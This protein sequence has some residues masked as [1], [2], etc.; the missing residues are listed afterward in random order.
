VAVGRSVALRDLCGA[1]GADLAESGE[2]VSGNRLRVVAAAEGPVSDEPAIGPALCRGDMPD[3]LIGTL[4]AE[5]RLWAKLLCHEDE[6]TR[7][8]AVERVTEAVHLPGP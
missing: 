4:H 8:L 3:V 2:I 1:V 6:S 5:R 7:R